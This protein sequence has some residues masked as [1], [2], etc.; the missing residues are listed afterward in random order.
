MCR[1]IFVCDCVL[2]P[3]ELLVVR[4]EG[5]P[6]YKHSHERGDLLLRVEVDFPTESPNAANM[7]VIEQIVGGRRAVESIE[8]LEAAGVDVEE[9]Q[10]S[11][12]NADRDR[13]RREARDQR[14]SRQQAEEQERRGDHGGHAAAAAA[15]AG[16]GVQCAQQ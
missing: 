9:C 15:A 11:E 6:H 4:G 14:K 1:V 3:G 10:L 16:G 8:S 2:R 5:M 7:A 12:F 13:A